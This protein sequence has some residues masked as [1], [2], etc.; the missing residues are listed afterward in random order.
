MKKTL[1]GSFMAVLLIAFLAAC[2]AG[3][4]GGGGGGDG[5]YSKIAGTSALDYVIL[6]KNTITTT[7]VTAISGNLGLSPAATAA[8]VGF[9]LTAATG[10]A[11][12]S[13]VTGYMFAAD[14]AP[15]TNTSLTTAVDN[16][17]TRYNGALPPLTPA[18]TGANLDRGAGTISGLTFN[19]G[20][21]TWT[22]ALHMTGDITL[23]GAGNYV[24]QVPGT[25]TVDSGK[26]IVLASGALAANVIWV[27]AGITALNAN[28]HFEG[29]ILDASDIQFVT[30]AS[31]NGRALSQTQVTLQANTIVEE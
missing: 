5:G 1:G 25:L 4:A 14:M 10:Y 27:V 12:S 30:G 9:A 26:K 13:N 6:A 18:G 29:T 31:L 2:S 17:L 24:F 21:Y 19:P 16:M 22:T 8:Y 7:G 23:S 3:A 20:T 28:S 15:P 11:T